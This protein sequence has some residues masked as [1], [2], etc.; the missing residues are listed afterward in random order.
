ML[1]YL[2]VVLIETIL[3]VLVVLIIVVS[4]LALSIK[5]VREYEKGGII[6]RL[7]RLVG[8]KGSAPKKWWTGRDLNPRPPE[9]SALACK[10]GVHTRLNYRPPQ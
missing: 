8:A 7:G 4:I 9:L 5:I 3:A 10:S 2:D 1:H 6:F